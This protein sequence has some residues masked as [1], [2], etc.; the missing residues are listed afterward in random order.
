MALHGIEKR[1]EQL[2]EGAFARAFHSELQP[3]ELGRRMLRE[4][5]ANETIGI[6]GER[7]CANHVTFTLSETDFE[8]LSPFADSLAA[9]LA[10]AVEEY[11]SENDLVLKGPP[12]VDL[13]VSPRQRNGQFKVATLVKVAPRWAA[14]HGWLKAPNGTSVAVVDQDAVVIGRLPECDVVVSDANVSRRHAE[15]RVIDGAPRVVDLGSVNGTRLNGHVVPADAFGFPLHDGDTILVGPS[16][17][18][19]STARVRS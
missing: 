16:S 3:V 2:V 6:R 8:R 7:I 4:L 13:L 12:M 9:E 18:R 19:F 17:I 11:A 5:A 14:A 10:G 15:V 1:L